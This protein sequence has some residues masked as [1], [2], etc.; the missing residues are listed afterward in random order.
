MDDEIKVE[1][2]LR[3]PYKDMNN[4]TWAMDGVFIYCRQISLNSTFQHC[5]F[6]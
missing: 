2:N 1:E 5:Y 3:G 6:K 4:W